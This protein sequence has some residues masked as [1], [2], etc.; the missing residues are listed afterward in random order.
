M[1]ACSSDDS[2][3]LASVLSS[4]A[5]RCAVSTYRGLDH[6][7]RG[8]QKELPLMGISAYRTGLYLNIT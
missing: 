4:D 1:M 2:E 3:T 8:L 7:G 6:A 5:E